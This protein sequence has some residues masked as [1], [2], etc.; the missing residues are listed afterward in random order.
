MLVINSPNYPTRRALWVQ[1]M[2]R[3]LGFGW[4]QIVWQRGPPNVN[5]IYVLA[6]G[7]Q[8]ATGL[9]VPGSRAFVS[10]HPSIKRPLSFSFANRQSAID[11]RNWF[12]NMISNWRQLEAS[13]RSSCGRCTEPIWDRAISMEG[14]Q[15]SH[16]RSSWFRIP[17]LGA[18]KTLICVGFS[19]CA[20]VLCI[21]IINI[22]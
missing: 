12:H 4:L 13:T 21:W 2:S 1:P 17:L 18:I 8:L 14:F 9:I 10:V 5:W 20:F 7:P 15:I 19:C 6:L 3:G 11:N 22:T 16:L